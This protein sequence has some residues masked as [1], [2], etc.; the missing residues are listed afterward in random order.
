MR[1]V[2]CS[3]DRVW[4]LVVMV[5]VEDKILG[6]RNIVQIMVARR[7]N[8]DNK[9]TSTGGLF[10]EEKLNSMHYFG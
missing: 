8:T 1:S 7:E 9:V 5:V 2:F 4:V 10:W 3:L 6:T